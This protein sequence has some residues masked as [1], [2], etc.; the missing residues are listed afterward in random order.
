MCGIC[1]ELRLDGRVADLAHVGRMMERL[2]RRGP[3]HEG[4]HSDG[5]LAFGHR[6]LSIIDLSNRSNQ[7][8]IDTDLDL[9]LVFNGTIYNYKELR[10]ELVT[11]GYHFFSEG[12]SE[13]ILK[14]YAEW[15][16]D[17]VSHLHGMFA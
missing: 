6:R 16:E 7:P 2:E 12:D 17:C 8:L 10:A 13:T 4:S 14:A 11:R 1:G 3:D 5:P 15:G 9:V